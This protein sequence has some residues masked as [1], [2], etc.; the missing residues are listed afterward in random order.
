MVETKPGAK[1]MLPYSTLTLADSL[2]LCILSPPSLPHTNH[3]LE[4]TR[5]EECELQTKTIQWWYG[6]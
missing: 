1:A 2:F 5:T 3:H 4:F 6:L